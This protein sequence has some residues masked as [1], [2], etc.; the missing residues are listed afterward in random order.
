MRI[1]ISFLHEGGNAPPQLAV[2][3]R[4]VERGHEVRAFSHE[5]GRSAVEARGAAF[6]RIED[7]LPG[8]DMRSRETDQT[9]D[10]ERR[11]ALG[12]GLRFRDVVRDAVAP[13]ARET[14]RLL[15]AWKADGWVPDVIVVD[16]LFLGAVAAAER[17]GIPVVALCHCPYP[18]PARGA[19]P[20][21]SGLRPGRGPLGRARDEAM[22]MILTRVNR[23]VLDALNGARAELG[24]APHS[25]YADGLLGCEAVLVM[26]APELDFASRGEQPQHVQYTGPA[27]EQSAEP[28]TSPWPTDDTRPLVLMSF[29]TTFMNQRSLAAR[30]LEAVSE[31]PVRA[32]LTTGPALDVAGLAVPENTRV[33]PFVPHAAVLPSAA[34]TVSHAGWGTV[35]ASLC[36]GVPLVCVPDARDQ[37]DNAARVVEAGAGVRLRRSASSAQLRRSIVQVL[38]DPSY[39]AGAQR[40]AAALGRLDGPGAAVDAI[41]R[42]AV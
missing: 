17:A 23:P 1:L 40:M 21:G 22:G 10:W 7:M 33:V 31:L 38:G 9:R 28:W 27:L 32:L 39:R 4:L 2:L 24:L 37:P 13:N 20:L 30:A 3:R 34:V 25:R 12:R 35:T 16:M 26:T 19:P 14:W 11:T 29:S 41:E 5:T 36:A 15:E 18:L 42:A 6:F 8:L